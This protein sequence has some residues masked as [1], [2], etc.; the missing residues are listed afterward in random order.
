[1]SVITISREA[2]SGGTEIAEAVAKELGYKLV[3]K[4]TIGKLLG[5][6]GLISFSK[7]YDN[8]P[9]FWDAFDSQKS[10]QREAMVA[11]MNKA[12]RAIA[13]RGNAVIVGR[14]GYVVLGGFADVL[15]VRIQAP[16][17]ARAKRLREVLKLAD[18]S[19]AE[20][21]AKER[22]RVRSL[23]ME[24]AYGKKVEPASAFDLV[25][26]TEKVP[27]EKATAL[28]IELARGLEKASGGAK[29]L[30]SALEVDTVL[31]DA[32]TEALSD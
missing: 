13:K 15:N 6:Y 21:D 20:K 2:G 23:F 10:D 31:A 12:F 4:Q 7:V 26:N 18:F 25:V 22:D 9:A 29:N 32:V 14:G 3:D 5:K 11:M 24:S 28:I 16:L 1:M 17:E 8:A 30:A 19:A 27:T